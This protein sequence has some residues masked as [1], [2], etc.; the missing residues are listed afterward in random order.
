LVE[1]VVAVAVVVVVVVAVS[2]TSRHKSKAHHDWQ[3]ESV[4]LLL[5]SI[6]LVA[7]ALL[8]FVKSSDSEPTQCSLKASTTSPR[9]AIMM[10]D[11]DT[12]FRGFFYYYVH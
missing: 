3:S 4:A 11:E 1:V 8:I 7:R 9:V 2:T 10:R 5:V 6:C 12:P